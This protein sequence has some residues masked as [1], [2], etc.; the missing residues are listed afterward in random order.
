LGDREA[1]S[2]IPQPW[3]HTKI[4]IAR[5]AKSMNGNP[6]I[7]FGIA[8]HIVR[9]ARQ[10]HKDLMCTFF[11]SLQPV[12][13]QPESKPK[14]G[15]KKSHSTAISEQ[16]EQMNDQTMLTQRFKRVGCPEM[17]KVQSE[18]EET[19]LP[20]RDSHRTIKEPSL[21]TATP[22]GN[23][24]PFM[25]TVVSFVAGSYL[26]NLPVASASRTERKN[27]LQ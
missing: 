13:P 10:K 2:K 3:K 16:T 1:N 27:C 15:E 21:L 25:S 18:T 11:L 12:S 23:R 6:K 4:Q 20:V 9:P 5:I 24:R 7:A 8:P 17:R 19:N 22:F 26:M 14:W